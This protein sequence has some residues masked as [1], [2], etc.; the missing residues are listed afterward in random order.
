M[1]HS[2]EGKHGLLGNVST[3]SY[4]APLF[5][6][7]VASLLD[8]FFS[9]LVFVFGYVPLFLAGPNVISGASDSFPCSSRNPPQKPSTR[10][11]KLKEIPAC[12]EAGL[13][14]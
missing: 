6:A 11:T 3:A 4:L 12:K 7:S 5:H 1:A 9:F 2:A 8:V 13:R 14:S 10:P